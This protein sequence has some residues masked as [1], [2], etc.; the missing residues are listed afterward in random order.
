MHAFMKTRSALLTAAALLALGAPARAQGARLDVNT[1]IDG[2]ARQG[3][4][5]LLIHLVETEK[6]DDPVVPFQVKIAQSLIQFRDENLP[7]PD[8]IA[9]LDEALGGMR[10]CIEQFPDHPQRPLWQTDL[11]ENL[12]NNYLPVSRN[13]ASL[14]YEFGLTTAQQKEGFESA[15]VEALEQLSDADRRFFTLQ[16]ELSRRPDF[17]DAFENTGLFDRL[18]N[19]YYKLRTQYFLVHAQYFA[20]LLPEDHPYFTAA[21]N[22]RVPQRAAN[23]PAEKA[24]LLG[25]IADNEYTAKLLADTADLSGVR[26]PLVVVVSRART[27][28]GQPQESLDLLTPVADNN[29]PSLN[30]Y[31]AR[32]GKAQAL[33][34]LNRQPEAFEV[35]EGLK[36]HNLAQSNPLYLLVLVDYRHR[37]L[38]AA[39]EKAPADQKAKAVSDAYQPYLDFLNDKSQPPKVVEGLKWFIYERWSANLAQGTDLT[40]LPPVVP[41]AVG[42]MST[43]Q[44]QAKVA[45]AINAAQA[46]EPEDAVNQLREEALPLL[47]RAVA[48]NEE[49]LKR[50]ELPPA[51]RANALFHLGLANY[52]QNL[53]DSQNVVKTAAVFTEL[54]HE[55]PEQPQAEKA[56]EFAEAMLR[57]LHQMTPKPMGVG[58]QYDKTASVM[59]DKYQTSTVADNARLY[60]AFHVLMPRSDYAKAYEVLQRVPFTHLSYWESRREMLFCKLGLFSQADPATKAAAR[61]AAAEEAQR[62]LGDT[63]AAMQASGPQ[64]QVLDAAG[65]ARLVLTKLAMDEADFPKA[66]AWLEDFETDFTAFDD[67]IRQAMAL[68]IEVLINAN[69]VDDMVR[70]ANEMMKLFPDDAAAVI[71]RLL[72]RLEASIK[73]LREKA[74]VELV[75]RLKQEYTQKSVFL[76]KAAVQLAVLLK[77]WAFTQEQ[78]DESAR[79]PFQL[80][81]ARALRLSGDAR[82]ALQVI[83]PILAKIPEDTEV[84]HNA[85]EAYFAL[86][87]SGQKQVLLDNA[88]PLYTRLIEGLNNEMPP[89]WWNAWMRWFQ[90]ADHLNENTSDIA[91][92]VSQLELADP[93]LGG[94]PYASELK[95]LRNKHRR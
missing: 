3:M 48:I 93:N 20:T 55:L 22:P 24:R 39:A 63:A 5:D 14:F 75:E 76:A 45:Q 2:L 28:A 7:V 33:A 49:L 90:I 89:I 10:Q 87:L 4:T 12:L 41:M 85:A 27:A 64:D 80:I 37:L 58:E 71:D 95:R 57:P 17:Q 84:I 78:F 73:D 70:A 11:A 81:E 6:F 16:G 29:E 25:L 21:A 56:I 59:F 13:A 30:N 36:A 79:I 40:A 82:A 15:V 47:R 86:G 9:A 60:Y 19:K 68:R 77:N 32:L 52:F 42:E 83:E 38:L 43:R 88:A 74:N 62:L 66:L 44:G 92:R 34:A 91:P 46:G 8:R 94:E 67:L 26:T 53:N 65:N 1:L 23:A 18:I 54:A 61:T 72:Q 69:R 50:P 35:I 51:I 31:L